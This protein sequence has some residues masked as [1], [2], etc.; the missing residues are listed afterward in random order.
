MAAFAFDFRGFGASDGQP[1]AVVNLERQLDDWAA[2]LAYVRS[3]EDVDPE[4][5]GI[6]GS[7]FTGGQVFA[8]AARDHRL[9]VA[10]A[11]VPYCDGLSLAR[12]AGI[13]RNLRL[14]PAVLRDL[15]RGA[16]G[17]EPYMIDAV[18]PPRARAVINARFA[19]LADQILS[20]I[21]SGANK[22]AARSLLELYRFR[23]LDHV[24]EIRCPLLVVLSYEDQIAPP[25]QAM[26][27]AA[28]SPCVELA[29]FHARHFDLYTGD[30]RE[31]ALRTQLTFLT[32]HLERLTTPTPAA[33]TV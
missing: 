12:A 25:E 21:P 3:R 8:V 9:A 1:R 20:Q 27:L 13:W 29:M 10:V 15:L 32:H 28:R 30:T 11:Q 6:W 18:G 16:I 24:D 19:D 22:T 5:I 17:G 2:A 33:A 26:R 23:P 7:S 4:L 14:L 31:R